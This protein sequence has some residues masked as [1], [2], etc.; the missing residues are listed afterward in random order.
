MPKDKK[1]AKGTAKLNSKANDLFAKIKL[2]LKQ[3]TEEI[4]KL[5]TVYG[6][7]EDLTADIVAIE[8]ARERGFI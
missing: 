2:H 5:E 4:G 3:L 7:K 1:F 6:N 8:N